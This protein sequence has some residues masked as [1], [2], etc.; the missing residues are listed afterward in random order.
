MPDRR[1]DKDY[2]FTEPISNERWAWEFLR[3]N[4]KYKDDWDIYVKKSGG[5]WNYQLLVHFGKKWSLGQIK[6]F[7]DDSI[8]HEW[9]VTLR[10]PILTKAPNRNRNYLNLAIKEK[11]G[12][13]FDLRKSIPA[14]MNYAK[15][16]LVD[17]Q[18]QLIECGQVKIEKPGNKPADYKCKSS[19]DLG[20]NI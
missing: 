19:K 16:L 15:S 8:P 2:N 6:D 5:E 18:K 7:K 1:K 9:L 20:Q 12:L 13:G 10:T 3:R 11:V 14:Q 4:P 17:L